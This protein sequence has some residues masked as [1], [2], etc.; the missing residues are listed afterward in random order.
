M[1]KE[2]M[3][4]KNGSV[5]ELEVG[6]GL[7]DMKVLFNKEEDMLSAWKDLTE[8]NLKTVKIKN[9]NKEVVEVYT[10]IALVSET[11]VRENG[12]ILTSF[13]FREK[14][15]LEKRVDMLEEG[16]DIQN[17]AIREL[18][19]VVDEITGGGA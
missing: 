3:E 15:E 13:K 19:D 4:L 1:G 7:S 17:G 6:S 10:D 16:Q 8:E 5:I 9:G 2:S 18:G 12:K 11:S 14:T